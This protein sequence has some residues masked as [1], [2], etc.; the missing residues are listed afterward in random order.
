MDQLKNICDQIWPTCWKL[1][2]SA[3][4]FRIQSLTYPPRMVRREKFSTDFHFYK[5]LTTLRIRI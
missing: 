5:F 3:L 1:V 2:T 4:N